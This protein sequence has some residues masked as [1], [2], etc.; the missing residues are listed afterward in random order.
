MESTV[1]ELLVAL[2]KKYGARFV[3]GLPAGQLLGVMDA[4]GRDPEI[5]YVTTRHEEAAGHMADAISRITDTLGVCFGTTGPGA[6]NLLPGVAAAW[7]DN[8]PLLAL[9]GNNQ[10][11]L[12]YPGH[13]NLQDGDHLG[14]YRPITKWNALLRDADRAPELI[15]RALR[16]AQSGRPGPVHLDIP[17]DVGLQHRH[18]DVDWHSAPP[19]SRPSGDPNLVERAATALRAA[20]RPLLLAGGGVVRSG[21]TPGF[22][23]LLDLTGFPATTT[24]MGFG[25]VPPEHPCN[26]GCGGWFG[27]EAPLTAMQEADVILAVGCKFS[28]WTLIDKPPVYPRRKGQLLIQVDI[29]PDML[30]KNAR[31]DLGI[32][33]DAQRVLEDL[34]QLLGEGKPFAAESRWKERLVHTNERYRALVNSIADTRAVGAEEPP[35]EATVARAIAQWLAPDAIVCFDGGQ[36]MEWAHTFVSIREPQCHLFNP[37]MGHLGFGQPFANAAKL[38]YPARQ[39]VNIVGDGAFGCTVQELETAARCGLNVINIVCNDSYWGMY[40]PLQ[41]QVCKNPGLGARLSNVNFARV[42]EGFGCYGE[43]VTRVEDLGPALA[44]A[45]AAKKPAVLDVLVRFTPHPMD[46]L[47]MEVVF[48]NVKVPVPQQR[49]KA[50]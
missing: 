35:N 21:A 50:A 27:G 26:I 47:W 2:L 43:R 31:I 14:L 39:V 33:G 44:R 16:T 48:A 37:G 42:A 41:E 15:E 8:I 1:S 46:R 49:E 24:L 28:T 23:A 13:D 22:R 17:V 32:V 10:S 12:I 45:V 40:K 30:G 36:V 20:H 3:C 38:A 5:T 7:A 34:A 9:T 25:V 6:T 19:F 11:Y 18:F 4:V 29:D